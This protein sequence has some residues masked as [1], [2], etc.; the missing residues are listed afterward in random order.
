MKQND[1]ETGPAANK[2]WAHRDAERRSYAASTHYSE[3]QKIAAER[4]KLALDLCYSN[5]GIYI[6]FRNK[7]IT[8]KVAGAY[9][10]NKFE[11]LLLEKEYEQRGYTKAVSAQG[12]IYRIPKAA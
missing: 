7:F 3:Q 5:Q 12:V 10:K 9:I 8:V 4:M 2:W 1:L 6:N 11:L